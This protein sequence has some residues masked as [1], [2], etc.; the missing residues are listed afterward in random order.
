MNREQQLATALRD[1]AFALESAAMLAGI[2]ALAEPAAAARQA[3]ERYYR[4]KQEG[5]DA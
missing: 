3:L 1:A 5:L 4:T 2:R